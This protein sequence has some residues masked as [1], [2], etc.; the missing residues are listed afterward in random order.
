VKRLAK[1]KAIAK[2]AEIACHVLD[3]ENAAK[4]SLAE[5]VL[6]LPMHPTDQFVAFKV[7]ADDGKGPKEIAARFGCSPATVRQRLRLTNVSP[8]LIDAYR[9][10]AMS[11]DQLMAFTVSDDHIAREKAWAKLAG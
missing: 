8:V 10:E 4:I 5:N 1:E 6:R 2:A 3:G 7:L 9:A 11:L